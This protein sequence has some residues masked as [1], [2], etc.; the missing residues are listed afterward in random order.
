MNPDDYISRLP[1]QQVKEMHFAG[2]HQNLISGRW[3]DH[4]S[5]QEKD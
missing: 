5:I 2:I 3:M 4:L 1:I